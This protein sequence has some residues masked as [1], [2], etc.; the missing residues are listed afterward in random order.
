MELVR[1]SVPAPDDTL[2]RNCR[3]NLDVYRASPT[4]LQ[5]DVSQESQVA[6]LL[7]LQTGSGRR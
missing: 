3:E 4:R 5:E 7:R 6:H 2:D 1:L